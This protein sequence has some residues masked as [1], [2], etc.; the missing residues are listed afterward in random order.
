[1]PYHVSMDTPLNPIDEA[2]EAVG[3]AA[4]LARRLKVKP[5]TIS[6][7]SKG[8]DVATGQQLG[9]A[10]KQDARPIPEKRCPEIE[11]ETAARVTVE[12]LRTD[13][14]WV[15]VVD[16]LWPHE[17]GRPCID[18]MGPTQEVRHAA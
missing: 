11:L 8:F 18:V 10:L 15:R 12:R 4:S 5:P 17:G 6:Q 7:W 2:C 9:G 16:P 13:V 14:R 1:M 3:G